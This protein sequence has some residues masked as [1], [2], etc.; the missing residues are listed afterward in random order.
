[1]NIALNAL[2]ARVGAGISAFVNLLP[3]LAKIDKTNRYFI[4]LSNRQKEI[5]DII[6]ETFR[7]VVINYVP[8]NP[9][10]RIIWEQIIFPFYILFYSINILYSVGN[11]TTLLAPCKVLLLIENSN[12]YSLLK[13]RW[14]K[15]ERLRNKLLK[16][17]GWL[18]AKRANKIRFVSNNSRNILVK[19]LRIQPDKCVTIYHG[20]N[21]GSLGDKNN[22][23]CVFGYNYILSVTTVAP[24]KNLD[25]LVE[26]FDVLVRRYKYSGN[27][28]IVGD[29]CHSH[30]I[31]QLHSLVSRLNLNDRIIFAGKVAHKDI[32]YYY[33]HADV[34][35]LTSIE[36][37]FGMPL[38]EAMGYS[39]PVAVSDVS[40]LSADKKYFIPFREIC[41][42]AAHYFNPFDP[43]DIA[44]GIYEIMY[45]QEYREQLRSNGKKQIKKYSWE[46]TAKSL[47]KIFEEMR[48]SK[49]RSQK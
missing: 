21:D 49:C 32:K 11:T 41:G 25:R 36:E 20:F 30:Y 24:H 38:V 2:S 3:V 27:L 26:A 4:F 37:T 48:R 7:K 34:F 46:T 18:S 40:P 45:N 35:V 47:V 16:Y 1:M 9:Y 22:K 31:E 15:K 5:W 29:L 28:L 17:L 12:P 44:S 10:V 13:I 8:P 33:T 23:K 6:P 14:S 19:Q 39:V 43:N 42:D